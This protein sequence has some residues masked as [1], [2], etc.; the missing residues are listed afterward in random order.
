MGTGLMCHLLNR[1]PIPCPEEQSHHQNALT[2]IPKC[3]IYQ[4]SNDFYTSTNLQFLSLYNYSHSIKKCALHSE[5]HSDK[6]GC[7]MS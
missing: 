3:S 1:F 2:E 6:M 7:T 4:K 5:K